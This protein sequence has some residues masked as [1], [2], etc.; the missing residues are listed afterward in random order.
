MGG[1]GVY[2]IAELSANHGGSKVRALEVVHRQKQRHPSDG[3]GLAQHRE[4]IRIAARFEIDDV[5]KTRARD[6][7]EQT[8]ACDI[9]QP[10]VHAALAHRTQ[11]DEQ[12]SPGRCRADDRSGRHE[13]IAHRT[14]DA[15]LEV[16]G[17]PFEQ[18]RLLQGERG[19]LSTERRP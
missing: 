7:A 17:P 5:R 9:V 13:R 2:V 3:A 14:R 19:R 8:C 16:V 12:R 15:A 10:T 6:C 4:R 18:I 1:N 11:R